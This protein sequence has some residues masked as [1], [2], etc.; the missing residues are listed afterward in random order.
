M[1][2]NYRTIDLY[3]HPIFTWVDV[4]T[5]FQAVAAMPDDEACFSYVLKGIS[6]AY[7]EKEEIKVIEKQAFL[8]KCGNYVTKMLSEENEG[9]FSSLTV[10]FRK[11]TLDQIYEN[12]VPSFLK[13]GKK[14][15]QHNTIQVAASN[16][17]KQ[18]FQSLLYYFE[19]RA[20]VTDEIIVLK[21]KE[22]ILL[23]LQTE[24][25]PQIL[26]IMH[27]LFSTH[28][29]SF[30]EIV[31]AHICTSISITELADLTHL[32]L[33]SFKR[34]FKQ[35]YADTPSN[36]LIKKRL[37]KVADLLLVSDETIGQ[38]A[39]ECGFNSVSHLSKVFK[40]KYKIS[41]SQYRLTKSS[42][43]SNNT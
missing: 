24:S 11:D 26:E 23:L 36:Y 30:K 27:N 42:S 5:P 10:H 22:I 13:E 8:S 43:G 39:H 7:S 16:L 31:E 25:S 21:L 40:L 15:T 33:S 28:T 17:I 4:K 32:S 34:K 9:I 2:L 3:G 29:L 19:H 6:H 35:I 38:I 1:I 18:Y 41:P 37:E 14:S 12:A 20:L